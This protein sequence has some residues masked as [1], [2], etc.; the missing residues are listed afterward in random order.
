MFCKKT[1]MFKVDF[2]FL[3]YVNL[4]LFIQLNAIVEHIM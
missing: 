3:P 1:Y 2:F 4:V